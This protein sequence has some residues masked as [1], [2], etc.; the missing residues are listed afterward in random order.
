MKTVEVY[1]LTTRGGASDF[2]K[3]VEICGRLGPYCLVGGLAVNCYVEPVYTLD[4]DFV[5][6]AARMEDLKQE[7]LRM[8]FSVDEFAHS[9]NARTPESDL[10]IQFTSDPRYQPFL[11]RAQE[12]E[13][14][15]VR[16]RVAKLE[17]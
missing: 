7:L 6:I 12:Q 13:V 10:R 8:G 11:D 9:L 16:V 1:E 4:A 17:D 2:A 5:L 3:I 14:L 15:G